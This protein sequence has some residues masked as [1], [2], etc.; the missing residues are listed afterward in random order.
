MRTLLHQFQQMRYHSQFQ[1]KS[2]S[3]KLLLCCDNLEKIII[4]NDVH[5]AQK[6]DE[7]MHIHGKEEGEGRN[8]YYFAPRAMGKGVSVNVVFQLEKLAEGQTQK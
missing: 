4:S 7:G 2:H 3:E 5:N 8:Q 1:I 6:Y